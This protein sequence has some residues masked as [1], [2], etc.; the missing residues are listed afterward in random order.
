MKLK[1]IASL[2]LAGVMAVSM[3]AGCSGNGSNNNN[4]NNDDPVV[5]T[6]LT[7]S[8]IAAL[9]KDSTDNATFSASTSL[10]SDLEMAVKNVGSDI[11]KVDASNIA[12]TQTG[13]KTVLIKID[14]DYAKTLPGVNT[15]SPVESDD[16]ETQSQTYVVVMP[17]VGANENYVAKELAK[18]I[19]NEP[20]WATLADYSGDYKAGTKD[21]YWYNF[22]YTVDMAVVETADAVTGQTV[23]VAAYTVTRTPTKALKVAA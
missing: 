18:V 17:T 9:D 19:D 12:T 20:D 22:D 8:V 16:K 21:E 10:E 13:I 4:N 11:S 15:V 6:G 2:M 1:K 5:N 23:Y 7:G 3:L 14:D